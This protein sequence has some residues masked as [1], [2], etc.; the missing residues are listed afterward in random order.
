MCFHLNNNAPE[1][2]S[3]SNVLFIELMV[4]VQKPV[5]Q[6]KRH[7][8]STN[9]LPHSPDLVQ[10]IFMQSKIHLL[11]ISKIVLHATI[12]AHQRVNCFCIEIV[13]TIDWSIGLLDVYGANEVHAILAS[14]T[15]SLSLCIAFSHF[16]PKIKTITAADAELCSIEW[17]HFMRRN[18]S[19]NSTHHTV[20]PKKA[21]SESLQH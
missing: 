11:L 5:H 7:L 9:C 19:N 3:I 1:C 8:S 17:H 2:E 20:V 10:F 16:W 14:W 12:N 13:Y 18:K 6:T 15:L 4:C 21:F